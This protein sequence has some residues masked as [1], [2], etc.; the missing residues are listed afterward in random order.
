MQTV[1]HV[2]SHK[3]ES[4]RGRIARDSKLEKFNL[5]TAEGKRWG[6]RRGWTKLHSSDAQGAINI[7]W[8]APCQMLICRVVNRLGGTP[9][10]ITGRFMA[11]LLARFRREI[12]AIHVI[13]Q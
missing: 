4:L 10:E 12:R 11:Y 9:S 1:I 5:Y 2:I 8:D 6:R 7:Q 3:G 13:P